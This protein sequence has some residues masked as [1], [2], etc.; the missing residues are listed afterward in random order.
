MSG[1]MESGGRSF[2]RIQ[3]QSRRPVWLDLTACVHTVSLAETAL[4]VEAHENV[5]FKLEQ[6][7]KKVQSSF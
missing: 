7:K 5:K 6:A 1:S 3:N 2:F 4:N